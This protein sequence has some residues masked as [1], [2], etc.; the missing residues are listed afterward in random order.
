MTSVPPL[1]IFA[2]DGVIVPLSVDAAVLEEVSVTAE[3]VW[4]LTLPDN[5]ARLTPCSIAPPFNTDWF[6]AVTVAGRFLIV[7]LASAS[8]AR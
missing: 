8:P 2:A 7:K 6:D 1:T 5:A 4:P 3:S